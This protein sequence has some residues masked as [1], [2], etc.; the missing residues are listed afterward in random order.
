MNKAPGPEGWHPRSLKEIKEEIV[1]PLEI[2]LKKSL[3]TGEVP[4]E[5]KLANITLIFRKGYKKETAKL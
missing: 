2:V 5:W 3:L 4:G 1:I